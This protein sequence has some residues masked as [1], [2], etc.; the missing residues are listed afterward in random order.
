MDST[1]ETEATRSLGSKLFASFAVT[2]NSSALCDVARIP[3]SAMPWPTMRDLTFAKPRKRKTLLQL[4]V[5]RVTLRQ[6][7]VTRVV[8]PRLQDSGEK[9]F[10]KKV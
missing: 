6:P 5:A 7:A 4:C 3:A 1:A 10:N 2:N 8:C 9:S